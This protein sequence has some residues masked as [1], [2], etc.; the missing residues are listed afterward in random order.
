MSTS[1]SQPVDRGNSA[2]IRLETAIDVM[3]P[4]FDE[5]ASVVLIQD[6]DGFLLGCNRAFE[7]HTGWSRQEI[8]GRPIS[9]I[10]TISEGR[11]VEALI[12]AEIIAPQGDD[13]IELCLRRC[14]LGKGGACALV[15]APGQ[16]AL[17]DLEE[18][19]AKAK[20]LMDLGQ[21]ATGVAHELKNPLTSI[22]NYADYLLDKY[23]GQFFEKRDGERLQRIVDGVERM[24]R[25][26]RDLLQLARSDEMIA[27]ENVPLHEA[28][29]SAVGLCAI[30]LDSAR[31][32]VSSRL[33]APNAR[34]RGVRS[35]L[36]QVFVNLITNGADAMAAS[37]GCIEVHVEAGEGQ[38]VCR[39]IDDGE[40]MSEATRQ[41][42]FE[43]FFTTR[44][45]AD[46]TGLGLAL[47]RTILERHGGDIHVESTPGQGTTFVVTLPLSD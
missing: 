39:V 23:R 16:V 8:T 45:D 4:V 14:P 21:L 25:F 3:M 15:G 11:S 36:E 44:A 10:A 47:V 30:T 29:H 46:G 26:V 27:H 6:A 40:G 33:E 38:A 9:Q 2:E 7:E 13:A 19:L 22:L 5:V 43:P 35:Q 1:K 17:G 18:R 42:I 34:V 28:V 31:I 24:D 37:G 32:S 12:E 20:H 41:R